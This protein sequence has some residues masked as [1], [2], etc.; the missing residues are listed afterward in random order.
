M[1]SIVK[2]ILRRF[3]FQPAEPQPIKPQP[4]EPQPLP[5]EWSILEVPR[6]TETPVNLLGQEFKVA[7]TASFYGSF[8]EIFVQEVYKFRSEKECPFILDCGSNYG[9]S[10]V[11]FKSIFPNCKIVAIEADPK[12]FDLLSRNIKQ[13]GIESVELIN[14]AISSSSEP[15]AFY[16]EGADAGRMHLNGDCK[17]VVYVEPISLDSLITGPVDFLKMDIEG[18]E[19][20]ALCSSNKLHEVD[21]IFIEYHS[22]K[23]A[24]QTLHLILEKLAANGFRYYI[25]T[26]FCSP[27]PLTEEALQVGMDLQLNIFAKR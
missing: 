16:Q 2:N 21:Q 8:G 25:H 15:V 17:N 6:Y 9:A 23:D 3:R 20:E 7:D 22:F 26:Q 13:R 18:A 19:T 10:I 11:Y 27:R 14:K 24:D 1:T 12:I 4:A 5:I